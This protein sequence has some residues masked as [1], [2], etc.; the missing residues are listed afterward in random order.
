MGDFWTKTGE[1]RESTLI[2]RKG[3][4][5]KGT[6]GWMALFSERRARTNDDNDDDDD[7]D[8]DDSRLELPPP[9]S[10]FFW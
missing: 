8:D 2:T 6:A 4:N 5:V 1:V 7:D 10:N 9:P 3:K